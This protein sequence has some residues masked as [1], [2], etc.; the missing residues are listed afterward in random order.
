MKEWTQTDART[1]EGLWLDGR[2][3]GY[4]ANRLGKTRNAVAGF[5]NRRGLDQEAR[6]TA[7]TEHSNKMARIVLAD[8]KLQQLELECEQQRLQRRQ[9]EL[10]KQLMRHTP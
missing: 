7:G 1:A 5:L 6:E 4:I 10:I 2:S 3:Y 9:N 8:V